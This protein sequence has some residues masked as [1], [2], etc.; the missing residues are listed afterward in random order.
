MVNSSVAHYFVL[1]IECTANIENLVT[2]TGGLV[3]GSNFPIGLQTI[4]YLASNNCNNKSVCSFKVK[5]DYLRVDPNSLLPVPKSANAI[6][7]KFSENNSHFFPSNNSPTFSTE[8][9]PNPSTGVFNLKISSF[10][11]TEC[12][13]TILNSIGSIISTQKQIINIGENTFPIYLQNFSDGVYFLNIVSEN[14]EINS[15]KLIKN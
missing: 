5:V 10:I 15:L 11:Y 14:Q 1:E 9:Y 2:Q 12:H 4:S 8:I 7:T 13:L 6:V 3:S